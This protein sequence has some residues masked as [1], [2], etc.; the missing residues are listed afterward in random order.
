MASAA[1]TGE[2]PKTSPLTVSLDEPQ[3][4]AIWERVGEFNFGRGT[5][6]DYERFR[7][8]SALMKLGT[9]E[10]VVEGEWLSIEK[11]LGKEV[12]DV[13]KRAAKTAKE[14]TLGERLLEPF[15]LPKAVLSSFDVSYPLRQGIMLGP[16]HPKEFAG[17]VPSAFRAFG[18]EE[19]A[20]AAQRSILDDATPI[21]LAD[22]P[23]LPFNQWVEEDGL[24]RAMEGG[25][26]ESEEV[27][28]GSL[29]EKIPF[30]GRVVRA[31]NRSFVTYGNKLRMTVAKSI[32][33]TW[34]RSG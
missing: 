21:Q 12:T 13:L 30:I 8:R 16:R 9:G 4:Q 29:A 10:R 25:L 3:K 6:P 22:G 28:R 26:A 19:F 14:P 33:N 17:N 2:K 32:L 34:Q 1:L 18:S 7:T 27:F 5:G 15:L 24:I 11:V 23:A 31:S 20:Q